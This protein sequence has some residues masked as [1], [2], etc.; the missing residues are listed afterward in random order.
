MTNITT[1]DIALKLI[2]ALYEQ[3]LLNL[4]TYRHILA[5]YAH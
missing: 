1:R 4:E 2:T 5:S 3:G